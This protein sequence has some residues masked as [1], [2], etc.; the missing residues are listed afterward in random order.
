M[1]RKP[2]VKVQFQEKEINDFK[3]IPEED[4]STVRAFKLKNHEITMA[5]KSEI[6]KL[7]AQLIFVSMAD[8]DRVAAENKALRKLL[9]KLTKQKDMVK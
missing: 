2:R 7:Q 6:E 9:Q 5:A 8:Y 3:F 4:K 1:A